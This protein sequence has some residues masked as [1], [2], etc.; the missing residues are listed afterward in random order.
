MNRHRQTWVDALKSGKYPQAREYLK[1]ERKGC[2]VG[3]CCLGVA[4]E[5]S[6]AASEG[7]YD[8]EGLVEYHFDQETE[9]L[10]E[11]VIDWI[12]EGYSDD[13]ALDECGVIPQNPETVWKFL[14]KK[15]PNDTELLARVKDKWKAENIPSL[16]ALSQLNDY[17][18]TFE[19]IAAI[20]EKFLL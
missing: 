15:F 12:N 20:I 17:G 13:K 1:I 4:C 18:C 14:N 19:H 2:P 3:Y 10:P 6:G 16:V 11:S 7:S 9:M 8:H 5:V